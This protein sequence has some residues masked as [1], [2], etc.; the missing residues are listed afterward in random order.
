MIQETTRSLTADE[1]RSLQDRLAECNPVT[2][3]GTAKWALLWAGGLALL[4]LLAAVLA[5]LKPDPIL[6][7]II[8]GTVLFVPGLVCLFGFL[9]VVADFFRWRKEFRSI[10]KT[11]HPLIRNVLAADRVRSLDVSALAVCVIEEFEDEG[12]GYIFA[13][14]DGKS[15]LLKGQKYVPDRG[16]MPWP[17]AQFSI[18]RSEDGALWVGIFSSGPELP[19]ARTVQI[20]D[21]TQAFAWSEQEDVLDGEPDDIL[22]QIMKGDPANG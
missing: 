6:A 17:A 5:A 20:R 13:L 16:D 10:S 7:G 8:T 9:A 2:A 11:T 22:K 3:C 15:L 18:V 1:R 19:P 4:G 14:G 21:C 12:A